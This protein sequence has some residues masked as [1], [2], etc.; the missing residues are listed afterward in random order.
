MTLSVFIGNDRRFPLAYRVCSSSLVNHSSIPLNIESL[1][2]EDLRH[3]GLYTRNWYRKSLKGSR[4]DKIDN[5]PFSTDFA[6]TRWL[7]PYLNNYIGWAIFCDSDFLWRADIAKLVDYKSKDYAALV[8]KHNHRP[9]ERTKMDNQIQEIYPRKNWSSLV[10]WNCGH[11][12]NKALTIEAVNKWSGRQLHSFSWLTDKLIGEIPEEWNWLE[13]WSPQ[14]INPKAVHFTRGTP[15][16]PG[17]SQSLY[18]EEWRSV[19]VSVL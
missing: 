12:A 2:E 11:P 4:Y 8:V 18:A 7:V 13:G 6:F 17:H 14:K 10:L 3:R 1:D 9:V 16:I 5:K 15:D 19:A